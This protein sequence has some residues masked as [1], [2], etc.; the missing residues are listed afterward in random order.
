L[1]LALRVGY[2]LTLPPSLEWDDARHYDRVA[3]RF[4]E[5]DGLTLDD[6]HQVEKPPAYPLFLAGLY[7]VN[8]YLHLASDTLLVRLAQALVG[9]ATVLLIWWSADRL[10][11]QRGGF[12]AGL[13]AAAYPFFIYYCGV[14]LSETLA[15]FLMALALGALVALFDEKAPRYAVAAGGALGLLAL[16]RASLLLLAPLLGLVWLAA[17][18]PRRRALGESVL[19][20]CIWGAVLLPW[21]VRNYRV[22][23][24]HFVPGT[25]TG[26]WS[27]YEG[28]GPGADG[29][30]RMERVQ[31]P[32]AV[33]PR[34][35]SSLD[36]Y[37]AD[38]YLTRAAL[39]HIGAEPGTALRLGAWK[40]VRLWNVFPNFEGFRSPFYRLVSVLGYVPVVVLAMV[41]LVA[42][43]R[44]WRQWLVLVVPAVYLSGVHTL[45][46]G[47]IRYREPAMVGFAVLAG[48]GGAVLLRRARR[49]PAKRAGA[50]AEKRRRRRWVFWVAFGVLALLLLAA[51]LRLRQA[52]R[53][54]NV[55]A[56]LHNEL[57]RLWGG[58]VVVGSARFGPLS[59]RLEAQ[60]VALYSQ[61][62]PQQRILQVDSLSASADPESLVAGNVVLTEL[63]V[64]GGEL[65]L[66]HTP[67]GWDLPRQLSSGAR[68]LGGPL[69]QVILEG[70][71]LRLEDEVA[72]GGRR[73]AELG[74]VSL[75]AK[76]RADG[77]VEVE[78]KLEKG[79]VGEWEGR[80]TI[81]PAGDHLALSSSCPAFRFTPEA[82]AALPQEAERV[83]R[84]FA[85]QGQASFHVSSE[86]PLD[87]GTGARVNVVF[88]GPSLAYKD[89]A[90]RF[91]WTRG[92]VSVQGGEVTIA[93]A[94]GRDGD[95][96]VR[97]AGTVTLPGRPTRAALR[98]EATRGPLADKLRACLPER[99]Y[100]LWD[101]LRPGGQLDLAGRIWADERTGGHTA[102]AL[103]IT[104]LGSTLS[105][106]GFP[107]PVRLTG[108]RVHYEGGRLEAEELQGETFGG[109]PVTL[110]GRVEG[111]DGPR[112]DPSITIV[113]PRLALD[114]RLRQ[115]FAPRY[116][117]LWDRAAPEGEV[118]AQ[119]LVSRSDGG[120]GPV[121]VEAVVTLLGVAVTDREF[122]YRLADL[123]GQLTYTGQ[124]L[125]LTDLRGTHGPAQVAL[126]GEIRLGDQPE[127]SVEVQ[128]TGVPLDDD[129]KR[130]FPG[131]VQKM[132]EE[133][134]LAGTVA[135]ACRVSGK[136]EAT[137]KSVTVTTQSASLCYRGFAYPLRDLA[138]EL[139]YDGGN[140]TW[141]LRTQATG[142]AGEQVTAAEQVLPRVLAPVLASVMPLHL[143]WY[144]PVPLLSSSAPW[145]AN[146]EPAVTLSGRA[147]GVPERPVAH[148]EVV[149]RDVELDETLSQAIASQRLLGRIWQQVDVALG[150][151][152]D[153]TCSLSYQD[154]VASVERAELHVRKAEVSF[155]SLP[156]PLEEVKGKVSYERGIITLEK[157]EGKHAGG[158][159]EVSR[160]SI[161]NLE[162]APS[163]EL[164]LV[165]ENVPLDQAFRGLLSP[166][167]QDL[168]DRLA[169]SGSISSPKDAAGGFS[170][171]GGPRSADERW[172]TYQGDLE[173]KDVGFTLGFD[174]RQV[175]GKL[176]LAG[177]ILLRREA[178]TGSADAASETTPAGEE[179]P[180]SGAP[181]SRAPA[182]AGAYQVVSHRYEGTAHLT[183]L[184]ASNKPL[185]N[186]TGSFLKEG[187]MLGFS[188]LEAE[189]YGGRLSG[190]ARLDL[191]G[192]RMSYGC[193]LRLEDV[194]LGPFVRDT[195][196]YR[197]EELA[198]R[199]AGDVVLQGT[200]VTRRELVGQG[201][202]TISQGE[203]YRMPAF[204]QVLALL[205]LSPPQESAFSQAAIDYFIMEQEV[206][207]KEMD[208]WGRGLN[209]FGSGRITRDNQLQFVLY[210]GFGR[211]ELPHIPLLSDFVEL[212]GKQL[213]RLEVEGTFSQP[214]VIAEPLSPL[215]APVIGTVRTLV[216]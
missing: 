35:T 125:R 55:A 140:L 122:P 90:Y 7:L 208:L 99:Y 62:D 31:W 51:A 164:R 159:L 138:G 38:R 168:W 192:E 64:T 34:E 172:L 131:E 169:A 139:R 180:A 89:F 88:E 184:V 103:D 17:R 78:G 187:T 5:G 56:R 204:L 12:L 121:G 116:Q 126:S 2:V 189:M 9:A 93:S 154:G 1:A 160:G 201:K 114:E 75:S 79:P 165:A 43:R 143:L 202:L 13:L 107:Y 151:R 102:F 111:L 68:G 70:L 42:R 74:L 188:N 161:D 37:Q 105:Y 130:A 148:W 158:R 98:L 14:L 170:I 145:R 15:I 86:V 82:L 162:Q 175:T 174:F 73:Q 181:A 23:R 57:A 59:G 203:L 206:T 30:P 61:E 24:G 66:R 97:L 106:V 156:Y 29:G 198:G 58:V 20:L 193:R 196:D 53:P 100:P 177:Q 178:A 190:A 11:G 95:L 87:G 213:M 155:R 171:S 69:P 183:D 215:S 40:L 153:V 182:G 124:A 119:C 191:E 65:L 21:V 135:V 91:S 8:H 141:D 216:K 179:T 41:G 84:M 19:V 85:P 81:S 146:Q 200:G 152:A 26:G 194:E 173:L 113:A 71:T 136:L 199:L 18:K 185:R 28:A 118:A 205:H 115:A 163:F 10:F 54:E 92:E 186:L 76:S 209:I 101:N 67:A 132:W 147:T 120:Q 6:R 176:S 45:F 133:L 22:T 167:L 52:L 46:V 123:H 166:G 27:L 157:L 142:R 134:N 112:P 44:S 77:S 32:E 127:V 60:G 36:E 94:E 211:G 195:F 48:A 104:P 210:T 144:A 212:M 149:A 4:L 129:L 80:A 63:H 39:A 117:E 16:T 207:I 110:S 108:G 25:L 83:V 33:W 50:G 96:L 47:S 197:G 72:G 150:A 137:A 49:V 109:A 128:G 214:V 3:R